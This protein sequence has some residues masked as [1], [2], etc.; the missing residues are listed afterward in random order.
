[1]TQ[2]D[3]PVFEPKYYLTS[4]DNMLKTFRLDDFEALE[5]C[6]G[7]HLQDPTAYSGE[8]SGV[9]TLLPALTWITESGD[10]IGAISM[11][12]TDEATRWNLQFQ[13]KTHALETDQTASYYVEICKLI[14]PDPIVVAN[15]IVEFA[16]SD[17]GTKTINLNPYTRADGGNGIAACEAA[18]PFE[19][20]F[21]ECSISHF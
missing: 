3:P 13:F 5:T 9:T 11:S 4:T 18:L 2:C 16:T 10:G 1:M 12:Y 8:N 14:P 20:E 21:K 19:Y 6:L 15:E 7:G 17:Q